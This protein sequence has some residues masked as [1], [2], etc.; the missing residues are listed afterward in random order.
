M[1]VEPAV[2]GAEEILLETHL[3]INCD[4]MLK[5]PWHLAQKKLTRSVRFS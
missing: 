1:A 2:G 5:I 4:L 3:Q